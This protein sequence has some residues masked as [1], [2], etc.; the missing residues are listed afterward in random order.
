MEA[1]LFNITEF[2]DG[3]FKNA[4]LFMKLLY[5]MCDYKQI[6]DSFVII[7]SFIEA[8]AAHHNFRCDVMLFGCVDSIY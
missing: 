7:V 4:K 6:A 1:A 2:F 8:E 3:L 5:R